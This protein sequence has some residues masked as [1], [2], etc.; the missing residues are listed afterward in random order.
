MPV[1]IIAEAAQGYEGDATQ[2]RLLVRAAARAGADAVKFQLVYA[3]EIATPNYRYY[4]LFRNLEMA[5]ETW[6]RLADDAKAEGIRLYLDVYGDRS[7]R[8]AVKLGAQGL[9]I[10]TTDFGNSR[11]VGA[12]LETGLPLLISI[13]GITTDELAGF[14]VEHRITAEH[15]VCFLHGF[16]AEPTPVEANNLRKLAALRA[17]FPGYHF[18]FMDHSDGSGD[19][20]L[21]ISLLAVSLGAESIE[22]HITLDRVLELED[23]VSALPPGRFRN[24]TRQLRRLESALGTESVELSPIEYEYRRKSMKVVVAGRMLQ[25]GHEIGMEDVCLKRAAYSEPDK[26]VLLDRIEEAVGRVLTVDVQ[27]NQVITKE[28]L[29]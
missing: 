15:A 12:A 23:Y 17:R 26:S 3:D 20:G 13:G 25:Q 2:A 22:K 18:G 9:K 21:S 14:L 4:G 16:Q 24:Y 8:E 6:H 5:P 28:M 29:V 11:L 7:L 19:D 27:A 1:Q 10:S